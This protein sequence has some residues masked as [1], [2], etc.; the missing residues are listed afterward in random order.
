MLAINLLLWMESLKPQYS[1]AQE[2]D[3]G[4]S[5]AFFPQILLSVWTLL[6]VVMIV[7][8]LILAK[9]EVAAP[10]WGKLFAAFVIT[11]IYVALVDQIGFLMASVLF[12]AGFMYIF[13]YRRPVILTAVAVIFPVTTWWVF[14]HLLQIVLPTSPW[15][16]NF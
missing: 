3:Y 15:F 8:S 11:G 9:T 16:T 14:T 12:S 5:P 13:G 6:C 2:Q 1:N 10:L 7:R 4:F